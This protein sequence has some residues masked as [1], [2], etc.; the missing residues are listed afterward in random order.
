[1][2]ILAKRGL[3]SNLW[4]ADLA[5]DYEQASLPGRGEKSGKG[6]GM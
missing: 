6:V 1:M 5:L 2:R 3:R 4:G